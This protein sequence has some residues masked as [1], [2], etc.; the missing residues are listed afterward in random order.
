MEKLKTVELKYEYG[1][2]M[3]DGQLF[4][5]INKK[6][7]DI[8]DSRYG[9]DVSKTKYNMYWNVVY[10]YKYIAFDS[11]TF[12]QKEVEKML[13]I[14]VLEWI[15]IQWWTKMWN[16]SASYW[17]DFDSDDWNNNSWKEVVAE[18]EG[19]LSA[20]EVEGMFEELME[21]I[22]RELIEYWENTL[23][24]MMEDEIILVAFREWLEENKVEWDYFLW[25]FYYLTEEKLAKEKEW[26][27]QV[28]TSGDTS[29]DGLWVALELEE[30]ERV[31]KYYVIKD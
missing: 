28:A 23:E 30:K 26:Y 27:T 29:I 25:D 14:K 31:E 1:Y 9:I 24:W 3:D 18:W 2:E 15:E 11:I 19:V 12:T 16:D 4:E 8:M 13:W 6:F 22:E 21:D 7:V 10:G 17:V 20:Y 5:Y